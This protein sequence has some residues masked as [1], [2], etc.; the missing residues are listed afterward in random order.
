VSELIPCPTCQ[1][2]LRIP[3][4]A[5][6][7]R[8]PNC[9]TV[10]AVEPA[11]PSPTAPAAVPVSPPP[12]PFDRPKSGSGAARGKPTPPAA[13]AP[14]A[15]MVTATGPGAP[16][17]I[18]VKPRLSAV[19]VQ[20]L[21]SGKDDPPELVEKRKRLRRELRKMEERERRLAERYKELERHCRYGRMT[22]TL[23][24]WAMRSQALAVM[25]LLPGLLGATLVEPSYATLI[26][27]AADAFGGIAA[28]LIFAAFGFTMAGPEKGRHIGLMGLLITLIATS[29]AVIDFQTGWE[30]VS[31]LQE[32]PGHWSETLVY[33]KLFAPASALPGLSEA[34]V[35]VLKGYP[36]SVLSIVAAG[37]EFT[38]LVMICLLI[39]IYA[40]QGNDVEAGHRSIAT[41]SR[42]FWF[43]LLCA[44]FRI[45]AGF[46]FDWA[47]PE[48]LWYQIGR[49]AH[50]LITAAAILGVGLGL[51]WASQV[52]DEV[53][54]IVDHRRFVENDE[55]SA[56]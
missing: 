5:A 32:A 23:L 7:I 54:E 31:R 22:V 13:P 38:R 10:L 25:L 26:A 17:A 44:M 46:G 51:F 37:L 8:C 47:Q 49:G 34:P 50:G 39:Q 14:V 20:E 56:M 16:M 30:A 55:K 15:K 6:M 18:P 29:L 24:M 42:V 11:E 28:L 40:T 43:L 36:F 1:A 53:E 2:L 19:N 33:Y 4:G 9:K 27:L 3:A 45:A 48:E 41:V 35:R 12:L 52:M 21:T